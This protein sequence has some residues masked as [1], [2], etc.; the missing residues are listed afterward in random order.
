MA[1]RNRE[2]IYNPLS[3]GVRG[4]YVT[5]ADGSKRVPALYLAAGSHEKVVKLMKDYIWR[6]G[7]FILATYAKN[8]MLPLREQSFSQMSW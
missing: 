3:G 6:D 4:C 7:D 5:S 2:S 1:S 8:G